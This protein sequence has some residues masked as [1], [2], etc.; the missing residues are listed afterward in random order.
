MGIEFVKLSMRYRPELPLVLNGVSAH[1]L[2]GERV[3]ICGRTGSG[4]STLLT[5]LFLMSRPEHGRI[6]VGGTDITTVPL[7]VLRSAISC[8]PQEPVIFSGTLRYNLDPFA[9]DNSAE[10]L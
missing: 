9:T 4:K 7:R 3:G 8:I 2:E 5:M 6:L 1:I 10:L